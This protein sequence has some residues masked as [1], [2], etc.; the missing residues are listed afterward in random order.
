MYGRYAFCTKPSSLLSRSLPVRMDLLLLM[1][2]CLGQKCLSEVFFKTR[3][4]WW[5]VLEILSIHFWYFRFN[6]ATWSISRVYSSP[7]VPW[8][9]D[10][11]FNKVNAR[12]II[13]GHIYGATGG[14]F[15]F[16][17]AEVGWWPIPSPHSN[18]G[19][20]V[21]AEYSV[22]VCVFLELRFAFRL[23]RAV[24]VSVVFFIVWLVT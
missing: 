24:R 20:P 21:C 14:L 8:I 4:L 9:S 13:G 5:L 11:Y 17:L 23:F 12:C 19:R 1:V 16:L 22:C 10:F 2:L 18:L 3:P 15:D 7:T 6:L